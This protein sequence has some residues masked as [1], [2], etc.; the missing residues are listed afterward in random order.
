MGGC[1]ISPSPVPTHPHLPPNV[2]LTPTL[3]PPPQGDYVDRGE[4]SVECAAMCLTGAFLRS[5]P[6]QP[7]GGSTPASA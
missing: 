2:F 6:P 5:P 4:H 7:H 3:F 1:R